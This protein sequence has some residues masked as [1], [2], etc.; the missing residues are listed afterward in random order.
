[1]Y[2]RS[3]KNKFGNFWQNMKTWCLKIFGFFLK[4]LKNIRINSVK[5]DFVEKI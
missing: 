1:M 3:F 2:P 4:Q 5:N